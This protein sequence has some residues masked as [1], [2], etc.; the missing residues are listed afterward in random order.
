MSYTPHNFR[1]GD[2]L[3]AQSLNEMEAEMLHEYDAE[4]SVIMTSSQSEAVISVVS[5]DLG[6]I[7]VDVRYGAM[8]RVKINMT[9]YYSGTLIKSSQIVYPV[10]IQ[11]ENGFFLNMRFD[12]AIDFPP[13]YAVSYNWTT[14]ELWVGILV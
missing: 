10:V 12:T 5:G 14:E 4:I 8:R 6:D 11:N 2:V 1:D 13:A 7:F 9:M 3:Y